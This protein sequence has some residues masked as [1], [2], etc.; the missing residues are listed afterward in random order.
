MSDVEGARD[1][2]TDPGMLLRVSDDLRLALVLAYLLVTLASD[3]GVVTDDIVQQLDI[4][5]ER[6][7]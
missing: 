7:K 2:T 6:N 4:I 1:P 5:K 3:A